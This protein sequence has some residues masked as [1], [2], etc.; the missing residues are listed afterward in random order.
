MLTLQDF[1]DLKEDLLNNK[2]SLDEIANILRNNIDKNKR[3]W[4]TK[5][6]KERRKSIIK[7]YCEICNS[8]EHLTLQHQSHPQ[9]FYQQKNTEINSYRSEWEKIEINK[10][11]FY[12]YVINSF[13]YKPEPICPNCGSWSPRERKKLEPKFVCTNA[14]CK[15]EFNNPTFKSIKEIVDQHLNNNYSTF[16]DKKCF[17]SKDKY[18]NLYNIIGIEYSYKKQQVAKS[19]APEIDRKATLKFIEDNINYLSFEDT[20]TA[21]RSCAYHWDIKK[22]DLCPKCN[23]YYKSFQYETCI[24]CLPEERRRIILEQIN[25]NKEMYKMH[26]DLGID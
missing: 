19:K 1:K 4:H 11:D 5:D 25:F 22:M 24:N 16:L 2:K 23:H 14:N 20:I 9:K 7:D 21:C 17:T 8:T 26:K 18:A 15:H 6:W 12:E 10:D 3:S 13:D